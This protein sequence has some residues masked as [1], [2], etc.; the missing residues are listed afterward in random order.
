MRLRLSILLLAL[1]VVGSA[2]QNNVPPTI[3]AIEVTRLVTV[4]VTPSAP[5]AEGESTAEVASIEA[6]ATAEPDA[7]RTPI[8]IQTSTPDVFPTPSVGQVYVAEQGFQ[9]GRM[10]WLEPVKQIWVT[11]TNE[12]GET[13]WSVFDDA[14]EEGM[15]ESDDN[16]VPP[17]GLFQP[18]RGFGLLW[19]TNDG[20]RDQI[21]WAIEPEFGYVTRYE[22]RAGGIVTESN[23]YVAGPGRHIIQTLARERIQ[24]NEGIW[25][26]ELTELD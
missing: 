12:R 6:S 18:E 20:V 8:F 16:I 7:T 4:V 24:F 14:F 25:T 1:L 19:R 13:I 21:G 23:E 3:Y 15:M 10:F 26:W 11:W 17:E 2:C 9:N 5:D 22:Y